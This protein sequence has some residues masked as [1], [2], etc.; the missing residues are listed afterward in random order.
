MTMLAICTK[1]RHI[2]VPLANRNI[3]HSTSK[4]TEVPSQSES[5]ADSA[6]V[7]EAEKIR[8]DDPRVFFASERTLL[9]WIRTSIAVIG[10]GFVVARFGLFMREMLALRNEVPAPSSRYSMLIGVSLV[11]LG[12]LMNF[13]A[14]YEHH[15]FVKQLHAAKFTRLS[16]RLMSIGV[17]LLIGIIG[18]AMAVYLVTID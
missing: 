11:L 17:A 18:S 6:D 5:E 8:I 3:H 9:A 7:L 10:L 14:A 12:V 15:H 2:V 4:A 13:A 16:R 1:G